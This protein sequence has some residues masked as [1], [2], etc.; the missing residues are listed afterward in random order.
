MLTKKSS[1]GGVT[2]EYGILRLFNA[3]KYTVDCK[4]FIEGVIAQEKVLIIE[5][6]GFTSDIYSLV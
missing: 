2:L 6:A 3:N 4:K 1:S 5:G